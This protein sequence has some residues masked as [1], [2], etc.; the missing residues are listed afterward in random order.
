M[1]PHT[2]LPGRTRP[3]NNQLRR[4]APY[5][6]RGE[7]LNDHP[8]SDPQSTNQSDGQLRD[9]HQGLCEMLDFLQE[10]VVLTD[11]RRRIAYANRAFLHLAA[12]DADAALVGLRPGEAL[13]CVNANL[14]GP[15]CG[16]TEYCRHCGS[17]FAILSSQEGRPAIRDFSLNQQRGGQ[18][19]SLDLKVSARQILVGGQTYTFFSMIDVSDEK[20]RHALERTFFHDILNTAGAL[21][22]LMELILESSHENQNDLLEMIHTYTDYL[23]RDIEAQKILASAERR[24]LE[25]RLGPVN[26]LQ[27][28]RGLVRLYE[29]Q[30][31][32][33]EKGIGI[34]LDSEAVEFIS[35]ENL[36]GRVIG[37]MIK[38]AL[39]ASGPGE[40]VTVSAGKNNHEVEFRVH[41][42]SVIPP[43]V[44]PRIFHRSFSTKGAN[45]G[46]GTYGMKLLTERYLGGRVGFSSDDATGT[47]FIAAYP[48][49]LKPQDARADG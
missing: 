20:R 25:V 16:Q 6:F 11:A 19:E 13:G 34:S 3:D 48:L 38:N 10:A 31:M 32:A 46:L 27:L 14:D 12:A 7:R 39:E 43:D 28:V 44:Q 29:K 41:N 15:S 1:D 22:G 37:N 18:I 49:F 30:D 17:L 9:H 8:A 42:Q 47:T 36:V 24:D 40:T 33:K 5:S 2:T 35:D 21:R 26:A 23:I 45:R 4:A